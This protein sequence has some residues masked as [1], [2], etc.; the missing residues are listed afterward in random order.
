MS[1]DDY[2]LM[3]YYV[4]PDGSLWQPFCH[5]TFWTYNCLYLKSCMWQLIEICYAY[6]SQQ[7]LPT[8]KIKSLSILCNQKSKVKNR[9]LPISRKVFGLRP[10]NL[11]GRCCLSPLRHMANLVW[12]WPIGE[13][14]LFIV[15]HTKS[16]L[17]VSL[18]MYC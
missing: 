5:D 9:F 13:Q 16:Q 12:N 6:T 17:A 11:V 1:R 14:Q 15:C 2:A 4:I 3:K 18:Y 8:S 7:T 10:W